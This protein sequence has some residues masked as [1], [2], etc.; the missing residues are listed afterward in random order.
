[1]AVV[2]TLESNLYESFSRVKS[3]VLKLNNEITKLSNA[4][5]RIV[6]TQ[7]K[8]ND[9]IDV[10]STK[11]NDLGKYFKQHVEVTHKDLRAKTNTVVVEKVKVKQAKKKAQLYVASKTGKKFHKPNCIFTN[12]IKPKM[13]IKTKSKEAMLN[14]GYKPCDCVQK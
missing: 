13:M 7:G 3:D 14:K 2:P 6:E 9:K 8:Y 5:A 1:M 10:F 12:N 11:V 4:L